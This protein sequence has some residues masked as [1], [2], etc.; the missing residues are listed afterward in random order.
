MTLTDFVWIAVGEALLAATFALGILVGI[1][2]KPRK[3]STHG[4]CNGNERTEGNWNHTGNLNAEGRTC[5]RDA[6]RAGQERQA[7]A[8]K[9]PTW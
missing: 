7:G 2:L 4:N 5:G 6:S 3:E 1:A 9:R 8:A